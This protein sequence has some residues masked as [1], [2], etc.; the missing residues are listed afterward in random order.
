MPGD[1][2]MDILPLWDAVI[3]YPMLGKV[4]FETVPT[5]IIIS[6]YKYRKITAVNN[7]IL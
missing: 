6:C 2:G 7:R 1:T 4:L 5:F 3:A